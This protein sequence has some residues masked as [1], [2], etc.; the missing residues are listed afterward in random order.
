MDDMTTNPLYVTTIGSGPEL[1][2]GYASNI[3]L[4]NVRFVRPQVGITTTSSSPI[5]NI[6]LNNIIWENPALSTGNYGLTANSVTGLAVSGGNWTGLPRGFFIET[7]TS[8]VV[9]R[10]TLGGYTDSGDIALLDG[11]GN[12]GGM[13]IGN[14]Y[15]GVPTITTSN[16]GTAGLALDLPPYMSNRPAWHGLVEW[17][18]DPDICTATSTAITSGSVYLLRVMPNTT[19]SVTKLTLLLGTAGTSLTAAEVAIFNATLSTRLADTTT[20]TSGGTALTTVFA[21]SAGS[22]Q[23]TFNT[24]VTLTAGVPIYVAIL[25]TGSGTM[26][27]F[28]KGPT[29]VNIGNVGQSASSGEKYMVGATA[30]TAMPGGGAMVLGSGPSGTGAIGI[31]CGLS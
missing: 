31:W 27:S 30:Q 6:S 26:P 12:T 11:G 19:E 28:D 24:S 21:G 20:Q 29:S 4:D 3:V 8:F 16:G 13:F 18:F 1:N 14:A 25:C 9:S 15:I 10:S 23:I 22:V 2:A 7:C 17:N 5:T